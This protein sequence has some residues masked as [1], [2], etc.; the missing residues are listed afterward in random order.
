M[1]IH[2][3]LTGKI[4]ASMSAT[5]RSLTAPSISAWTKNG[6][7]F[8]RSSRLRN[9]AAAALHADRIRRYSRNRPVERKMYSISDAI[10][11]KR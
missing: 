5:L 6:V 1:L 8:V 3:C 11:V 9:R 10:R 2:Y 7:S 4:R